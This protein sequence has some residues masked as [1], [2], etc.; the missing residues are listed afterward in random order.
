[1]VMTRRRG[2][3]LAGGVEEMI[4]KT[5]D[6]EGADTAFLRGDGGEVGASIE[7]RGEVAFDNAIFASGASIYK[8]GAGRNKVTTD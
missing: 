6:G 3:C 7:V 8:N 5:S 1:M 4:K 2:L